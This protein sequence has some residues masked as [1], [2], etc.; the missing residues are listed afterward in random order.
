MFVH[1]F[2]YARENNKNKNRKMK[3]I[4]KKIKKDGSERF[5]VG[6]DDG[7]CGIVYLL[8]VLVVTETYRVK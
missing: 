6:G 3:A 1:S 2:Q 5:D 4:W 8:V 7:D